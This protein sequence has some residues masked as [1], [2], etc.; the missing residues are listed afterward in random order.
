MFSKTIFE[1]R[2]EIKILSNMPERILRQDGT[3]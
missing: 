1:V 2:E 3:I